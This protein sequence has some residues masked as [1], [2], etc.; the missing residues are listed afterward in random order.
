MLNVLFVIDDIEHKYFE[1]NDLVTNF[2]FIKELLERNYNVDICLK[3]GLW[4]DGEIPFVNKQKAFLSDK[5]GIS[6]EKEYTT[7]MVND[8]D[9]VFFRPDP[10][11]DENY[12]NA[13]SVFDFVDESKTLLINNPSRIKNF[14]EKFHC[15]RFPQCVVKSV[16]TASEDVINDFIHA[17]HQAVIKPLNQCF[18]KGVYF[19]DINDRNLNSIIKSSTND[20]K[21]HVVLQEY[22]P[23][24]EQGDKRVLIING[25]VLDE[26]ITKLP[27]ENSFKFNTHSDKYFK[28]TSLTPLERERAQIIAD[29]L[30]KEG[31]YLIGLDMIG[32]KV[33]EINITS[34]CF[35]IRE[36]NANNNTRFQDKIMNKIEILINEKIPVN[37]C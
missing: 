19:I 15:A 9:I 2:W 12:L 33:T 36:I 28:Q 14:G 37:V 7:A 29:E 5:M 3:N 18:G 8:Y 4:M 32:E 31:F 25:E 11:V 20:F 23:E 10:P 24:V 1:F 27:G 35:F 26:C 17:H 6:Y 16:V 22:L 13:C 21:T 34:P 30:K